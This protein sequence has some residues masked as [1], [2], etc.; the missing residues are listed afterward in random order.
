ML[1]S[2]DMGEV[3]SLLTTIIS[4]AMLGT[5]ISGFAYIGCQI[6]L[7]LSTWTRVDEPDPTLHFRQWDRLFDRV[8]HPVGE[9]VVNEAPEPVANRALYEL[10]VGVTATVGFIG[11]YLFAS[12]AI[13]GGGIVSYYS[14]GFVPALSPL[15]EL[16]AAFCLLVAIAT[17]MYARERSTDVI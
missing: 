6:Q 9:E 17:I 8:F 7:W 3:T 11:A 15:I 1:F 13:L 2:V 5:I 4:L 16:V 12:G 14:V 10:V